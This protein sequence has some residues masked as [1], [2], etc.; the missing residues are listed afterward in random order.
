MR[1]TYMLAHMHKWH[2]NQQDKAKAMEVYM[3]IYVM[4]QTNYWPIMLLR[5][6]A[7]PL[8]QVSLIESLLRGDA[9][10]AQSRAEG[11]VG[12]HKYGGHQ[13]GVIQIR[14]QVCSLQK[15]LLPSLP[16]L[17]SGGM[18][19]CNSAKIGADDLY[20]LVHILALCKPLQL[21][22]AGR[23]LSSHGTALQ[24]KAS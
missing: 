20:L 18:D 9:I 13:V 5:E 3:C 7:H 23:R 19:A 11:I 12:W 10:L 16:S 24:Q 14:S 8:E 22:A 2:G 21:F 17:Y 4:L 15:Q 1:T 6:I